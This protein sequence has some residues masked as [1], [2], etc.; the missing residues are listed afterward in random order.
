MIRKST[1]SDNVTESTAAFIPAIEGISLTQSVEYFI[2]LKVRISKTKKR[3]LGN[4]WFE[5]SFSVQEWKEIKKSTIPL[6][7][8]APTVQI[9]SG[10]IN[11]SQT[12]TEW[13]T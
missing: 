5:I 4:F 9:L 11:I 3:K 1:L 7:L 12:F 10:W 2:F 8:I 13:R 6:K